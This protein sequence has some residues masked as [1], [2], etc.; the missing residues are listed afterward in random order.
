M[1]S[2]P[3][4]AFPEPPA[5]R[6]GRRFLWLDGFFSN[7]SEA[8]VTSFVTPFAIVLGASN[9][10]VGILSSLTNL[11][12]ALGVIPGAR[13]EERFFSRKRIVALTSGGAARLLLFLI[14]VM[15]LLLPREY[16]TLAFITMIALRAFLGQLGYPAWSSLLADLVPKPIR[17]RYFAGR[18]IGLGL[19]TLIF[20][21]VAGWLIQRI[22][23]HEGYQVGFLVAGLVGIVST[24]FFMRIPEPNRSEP[25]KYFESVSVREIFRTHPRFAAFTTVTFLW[26]LAVMSVAPFLTVHFVRNLHATPTMIGI[27]SAAASAMNVVG[28]RFWGRYGDRYSS[29][30][31]MRL[32]GLM[33]PLVPIMWSLAPNAWWV[34]PVESFSGFMWA[35]YQLASFNLM[36]SLA[37]TEQRARYYAI[38]QT[39]AFAAAFV[40]PLVGSLLASFWSLPTVMRVTSIGRLVA[41]ILFVYTVR[42]DTEETQPS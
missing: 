2:S 6:A 16:A 20:T 7:T 9:L 40:G 19:A 37:P 29:V 30:S 25:A 13:L 5:A 17:G 26:N 31:V 27:L 21:P 36:L 42:G 32:T 12:S 35:G 22:G 1:T 24:Y 4:G 3:D 8:F 11:S 28:Q 33:I 14:A 41:A 15:P 18:N 34:V 23:G 38:F 39:V 10:Q